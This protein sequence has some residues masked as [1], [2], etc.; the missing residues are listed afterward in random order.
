MLV[1]R[2][3]STLDT[4]EK[5]EEIQFTI[6]VTDELGS[7]TIGSVDFNIFDNSDVDV[8]ADFNGGVSDAA[9][10][11]SFGVMAHDEGKYKLEFIVTCNE[12]LPDGLTP[13]EFIFYMYV[14]I[15]DI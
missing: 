1:I 11:I 9:G 5:G 15:K 14:K 4:M 13:Y 6:D 12:T 10:V 8:N 3:S 7:N 2:P